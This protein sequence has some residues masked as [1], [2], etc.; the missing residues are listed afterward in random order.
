MSHYPPTTN[1]PMPVPIFSVFPPFFFVFFPFYQP[2]CFSLIFILY[3]HIVDLG[4]PG[5]T[6][7]KNLP[8]N[9]GDA[10]DEGLILSWEGPL[11]QEMATHSSILGWKISWTEEPGG[12]QS[13]GL[14]RC[15]RP[16]QQ[17]RCLVDKIAFLKLIKRS[18][19]STPNCLFEDNRNS[20][21]SGNL[22]RGGAQLNK[23]YGRLIG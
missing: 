19:T 22:I 1:S 16:H 7:V 15:A 2:L 13:M 12:L 10:R 20:Y 14:Q 6:V 3:W 21:T 4:F 17:N 18:S 8:A 23:N 11:E 9:A 5:G